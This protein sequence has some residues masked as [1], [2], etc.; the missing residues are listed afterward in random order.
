MLNELM[1]VLIRRK[2]ETQKDQPSRSGGESS[3]KMPGTHLATR[4]ELGVLL[5]TSVVISADGFRAVQQGLR[6]ALQRS[7]R[8][9]P[10]AWYLTYR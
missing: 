4:N 7:K 6:K 1:D 3:V 8:D 5:Q 9:D 2:T 10:L